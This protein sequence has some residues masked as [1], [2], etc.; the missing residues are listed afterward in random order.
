MLSSLRSGLQPDILWIASI[1]LQRCCLQSSPSTNEARN[2]KRMPANH[3]PLREL[4]NLLCL[5]L[6]NIDNLSVY[7]IRKLYCATLL[8]FFK[9]SAIS[10]LPWHSCMCHIRVCCYHDQAQG[11]HG[12]FRILNFKST[13]TCSYNLILSKNILLTQSFLPNT[14]LMSVASVFEKFIS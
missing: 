12:A 3:D 1:I 13:S 5:Y 14:Y 2:W 8:S 4:S 10:N 11:F 7:N 9:K 6:K